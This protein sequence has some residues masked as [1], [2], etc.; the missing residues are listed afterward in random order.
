MYVVHDI[1]TEDV[2]IFFY[3]ICHVNVHSCTCMWPHM[4]VCMSHV[5]MYSCVQIL[6]ALA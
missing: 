5:C 3:L 2:C 6:L 1:C 4:Y